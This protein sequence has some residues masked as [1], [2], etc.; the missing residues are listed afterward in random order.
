MGPTTIPWTSVESKSALVAKREQEEIVG[1][2]ETADANSWG[3][4]RLPT[5]KILTF[6]YAD[7]GLLPMA[8]VMDELLIVGIDE[9][10]VGY[11]ASTLERV[12]VYRMPSIFHE[13]LFETGRLIVRDEVGFVGI[14]PD[15]TEQWKE[16]TDGP[17]DKFEIDG[18]QING[19]TI[20][21]EK[22]SFSLPS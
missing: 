10:L 19:T 8:V 15:G 16:L 5:G 7:L 4:F 9:L 18:N 14:S 20:D 3:F 1:Q 2:F 22:F 21:G 6:G 12:F 11:N 13:F 17:I